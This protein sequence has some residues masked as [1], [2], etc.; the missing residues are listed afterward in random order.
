M[1]IEYEGEILPDGHLSVD[2]AVSKTLRRGDRVKVRI[3]RIDEAKR[4]ER[5]S[6]QAEALLKLLKEAPARG[7]YSG[8]SVTREWIHER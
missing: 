7:G 6:A 1:E 3:T 4:S 2:P 5:L 8:R